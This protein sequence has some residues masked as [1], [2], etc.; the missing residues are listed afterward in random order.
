MSGVIV[1]ADTMNPAALIA[2]VQRLE[3]LGYDSVWIPDMFGREIYVTA[4]YLLSNT[5]TMKVAT[6][7]AHVYGRDAIATAQAARTLSEL[8]DGRFILGLGISHPPAAELRGLTWQPPIDKIRTY[9]SD[10]R[11]A[12]AGGLLHTPANPPPIPIFLAAHGPKMMQVA[13]DLADGANTY[14]QPAEHTHATRETLGPTKQLSVVLP[15]V[16]T[17]DADAARA[18]GRRAL[19][20]YL[21]LPAYHRQWRAFGFDE[22]DWVGRASD[23]LVDAHV[24]WGS[25]EEI[26]RR[27][28]EHLD[29]GATQVQL[30]VNHA[31][32]QAT[33]PPW[34]LLEALAPT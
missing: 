3:S 22:S 6:G 25:A 27:I 30:A 2:Y 23:R 10:V 26:Q 12:V 24:A 16:L 33:E 14:M 13:A 4:G 28:D 7:I 18:A 8:S 31:D 29:A 15:C 32:K 17:T 34:D 20:I 11:T 9:L 19:H 21:P 5:T 1:A